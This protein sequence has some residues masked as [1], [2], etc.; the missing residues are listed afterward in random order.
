MVQVALV[1]N[2]KRARMGPSTA[3]RLDLLMRM[4]ILPL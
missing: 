2:A 3:V 4:K 1:A